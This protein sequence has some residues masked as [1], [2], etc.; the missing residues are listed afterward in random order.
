MVEGVVGPVG[1]ILCIQAIVFAWGLLLIY[2]RD[3]L[4]EGVWC[5]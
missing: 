5:C 3:M 2:C 4:C 1:N